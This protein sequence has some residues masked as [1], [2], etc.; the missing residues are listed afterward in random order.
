MSQVFTRGAAY[1]EAKRKHAQFPTSQAEVL[2]VLEARGPMRASR[3]AIALGVGAA[4][5]EEA[6][7]ALIATGF[8]KRDPEAFYELT[9]QR[10]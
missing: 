3:L 1:E 9:E 8:I 4:R 7:A 2:R 10:A 5:V 6:C